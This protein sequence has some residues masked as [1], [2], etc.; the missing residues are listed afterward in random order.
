[1]RTGRRC[2]TRATL[3]SRRR[4]AV[5]TDREDKCTVNKGARGGEGEGEEKDEE[6][7]SERKGETR[8]AELELHTGHVTGC[9]TSPAMN[10]GTAGSSSSSTTS[11][12]TATLG[13]AEG[14]ATGTVTVSDAMASCTMGSDPVDAT[15]SISVSAGITCVAGEGATASERGEEEGGE[16][17]EEADGSKEVEKEP[18]QLRKG[19]EEAKAGVVSVSLSPL[20]GNI[21]TAAHRAMRERR[22]RGAWLRLV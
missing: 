1:M 9:I 5:R 13:E 11:A 15:S 20:K 22:R 10:N 2:A 14:G 21:A 6:G 16:G 8:E 3:T 17:K 18:S 4:E 7:A 12:V 19:E